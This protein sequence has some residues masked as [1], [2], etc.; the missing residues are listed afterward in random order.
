M[1]KV[2][3]IFSILIMATLLSG[4]TG[5]GDKPISSEKTTG[6]KKT[7][8]AEIKDNAQVKLIKTHWEA[9]TNSIDT[10]YAIVT[11]IVENTGDVTVELDDGAGSV[12]DE[13]GKVVGNSTE[14]FSPDVIAP[15]EKA[16]VGIKIMDTV[17]KE[18]IT[19]SKI[20][21]SFEKTDKNPVDIRAVNDL[22]KNGDFGYIITGELENQSSERIEDARVAAMLYDVEG[23]LI[24]VERGYPEPDTIPSKGAV[25]FKVTSSHLEDLIADYELIGF[26]R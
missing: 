3:T 8:K 10:N 13:E 22:G 16:Y 14:T 18:K 15:G 21:F 4:C 1:K 11:G 7:N 17:V 20:Q 5:T 9:Y 12:Y 2:L 25:S 24:D 6:E 19:D 26:T 23:N